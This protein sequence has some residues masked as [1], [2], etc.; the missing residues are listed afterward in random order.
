MSTRKK[1]KDEEEE[2]VPSESSSESS[3][4][5]V[6]MDFQVVLEYTPLPK[7]RGATSS[8]TPK[9]HAG[10]SPA[11]PAARLALSPAI[12]RMTPLSDGGTPASSQRSGSAAPSSAAETEEELESQVFLLTEKEIEQHFVTQHNMKL[13]TLGDISRTFDMNELTEMLMCT[14]NRLSYTL[15]EVKQQVGFYLFAPFALTIV[16]LCSQNRCEDHETRL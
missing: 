9:Q 8:S 7:K 11:T 10:R 4:G 16:G 6:P 13:I 1:R 3:S 14:G 5:L 2:Y 15:S 12:S